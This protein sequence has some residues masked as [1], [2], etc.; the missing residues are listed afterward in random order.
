MRQLI[1]STP[2]VRVRDSTDERPAIYMKMESANPTGSIRDRYLGEILGRAVQAGTLLP[3]DTIS[4]A[5]I[6]DSS[7]SAAFL[8]GQ[9]DLNLRLFAPTSESRRLLPLLRR[10][11]ADIQWLD[12]ESYG[13][14]MQMAAEWARQA[15]DRMF[16]DGYR[17]QAVSDAYAEVA[18]EIRRGLGGLEPGAFVTSVTT[19]GAYRQVAGQL[20]DSH[21][22]L[23][24]GGAVL[25]ERSFPELPEDR[26]NVLSSISLDRAWAR[27]DSLASEHGHLLGPKGAAAFDLADELAERIDPSRSVVALN[28]DAGQRYLGWEDA[29]LFDE[30]RGLSKVDASP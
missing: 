2:M 10:Y 6:D 14:A 4:A 7:V 24:V 12:E 28:P 18:D 3:G 13:Q 29:D 8:T 19:G 11:E 21:P 1:G 20:R 27:R 30:P 25:T 22:D 5:G 16:I 15:S 17:P 23:V 9:Y 26:R